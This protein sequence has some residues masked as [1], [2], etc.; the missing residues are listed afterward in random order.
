MKRNELRGL[1]KFDQEEFESLWSDFALNSSQSEQTIV[2][3]FLVFLKEQELIS[4]GD[5]QK[6]KSEQLIE[7]PQREHQ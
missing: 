1:L 5:Y 4:E 7:L 3:D 6:I 2:R